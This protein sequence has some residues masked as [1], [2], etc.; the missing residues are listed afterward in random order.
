MVVVIT[1]IVGIKGLSS[2]LKVLHYPLDIVCDYM[3]LVCLNHVPALIRRFTEV[4]SKNDINKID[5]VL[6]AIRL[7]HD[8]NVRYNYSIQ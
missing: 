2:L 6:S 1:S 3:H 5:S 7:P 4:L 8:V